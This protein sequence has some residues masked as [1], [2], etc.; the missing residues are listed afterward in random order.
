MIVVSLEEE[1]EKEGNGKDGVK[2]RKWRVELM[3]KV[4]KFLNQRSRHSRFRKVIKG[5]LLV[6]FG[7]PEWPV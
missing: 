1:G 7:V 6:S 3:F 5:L 2:R 4:G